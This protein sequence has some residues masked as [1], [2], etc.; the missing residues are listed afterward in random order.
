MWPKRGDELL[1]GG[2]LY[3]VF[4][5][6]VLARQRILGLEPR[7]GADGIGRCAI[8][9]DPEVV[10]TAPQPRR[11]FQGWRYLRPEDAPRDL[12]GAAGVRRAAGA[13]RRA[14][15]DRS[16]VSDA[17]LRLSPR[18][19]RRS[20]RGAGRLPARGSTGTRSG[21]EFCRLTLA[22][23]HAGLRPLLTAELQRAID[24]AAANP[25]LLPARV[26]FQTYTNEVPVCAARTRNAAL[27]EINRS[28]PGGAPPSWTEYLVIVPGGRRHQPDRRRALR[29]PQERH[30]AGAARLLR[31]RRAEPRP[32]RAGPA[33][34]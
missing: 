18:A 9:L 10:R 24:A 28:K 19:R 1:A 22:G 17:L 11:P 31:R 29:H 8:R 26:L 15:R 2:S 6:L 20:S 34:R 3:W 12:V 14:G 30:A 7:D 23:R 21:T 13:G 5:G 16:A 25:E 4:R 27:V 33:G 32:A